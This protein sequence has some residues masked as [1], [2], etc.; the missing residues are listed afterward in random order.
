MCKDGKWGFIDTE[1]KEVIP[2]K[3]KYARDFKNGIAA[4]ANS[5]GKYGYIATDGC[6]VI[7]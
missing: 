7:K 6:E 4:V 3:Y 2:P 1:F 5:K